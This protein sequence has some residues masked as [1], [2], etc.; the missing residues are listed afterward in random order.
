MMGLPED[1]DR[2]EE[3]ISF[4]GPVP[5]AKLDETVIVRR[6]TLKYLSWTT[7]GENRRQTFGR[8]FRPRRYRKV[9]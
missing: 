3:W 1:W 6:R 4:N 9:H 7:T 8:N 5:E 2:V